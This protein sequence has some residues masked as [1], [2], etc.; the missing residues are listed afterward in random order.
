MQR[1]ADKPGSEGVLLSK[2]I[3]DIVKCSKPRGTK[4]SMHSCL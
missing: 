1:S 4:E 3:D 2:Q